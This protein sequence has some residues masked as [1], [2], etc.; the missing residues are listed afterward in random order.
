LALVFLVIGCISGV[1]NGNSWY[2][3]GTFPSPLDLLLLFPIP[4]SLSLLNSLVIVVLRSFVSLFI[5]IQP[6]ALGKGQITFLK[7]AV[8]GGNVGSDGGHCCVTR[9][10]GNGAAMGLQ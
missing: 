2:I 6:L 3:L 9:W 1:G 10:V 7:A 5:H 4:A 8:G